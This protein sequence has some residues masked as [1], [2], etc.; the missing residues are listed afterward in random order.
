MPLKDREAR[1][2]YHNAYMARRYAEDPEHKARHLERTRRNDVR[3]RNEAKAAIAA[4]RVNGC[5]LCSENE[6]A[7][8]SAHHLDA[9][10]KEFNVGDAVRRKFSRKKVEEELAKCV[11]LCHNCHAKVHAGSLSLIK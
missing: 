2:A 7:C 4:F 1:K 10:D 9:E 8:L 11:C 5:A 3:Y 6:E